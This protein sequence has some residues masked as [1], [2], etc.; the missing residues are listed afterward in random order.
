MAEQTSAASAESDSSAQPGQSFSEL[1]SK[2][3]GQ[4]SLSAWLP[5]AMLV[6]PSAVLIEISREKHLNLATALLRL[7]KQPLGILVVLLFTLIL[8][9]MITQAF[10]FETIRLLE[11]YWSTGRLQFAVS[12]AR[13]AAHLKKRNSLEGYVQSLERELFARARQ[14]MLDIGIN[15]PLIDILEHDILELGPTPYPDEVIAEARSMGW[16]FCAK[17]AE[18]RRLDAATERLALYPDEFRI[19]PTTLGNTLRAAEDQLK[20]ADGGDLQ[21]LIIRNYDRIP[22]LLRGQHAQFR[23]KLDMYCILVFVF[24]VLAPEATWSMWRFG[25]WHLFSWLAAAGFASLSILSYRAA[26]SSARGYGAVLKAVDS[27][28]ADALQSGNP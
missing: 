23:T 7:T 12:D 3:F 27:A 9:T 4:L 22:S 25:W 16:Q 13:I 26:I 24:A 1:I 2:I 10:E 18:L 19:L 14:K 21:G 15:R 20:L 6:G 11:G 17:P 28:V 8:A 5:A